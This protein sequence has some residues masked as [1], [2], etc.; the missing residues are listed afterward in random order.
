MPITDVDV[1]GSPGWW[2][3]RLFWQLGNRDRQNRI[4]RLRN[5]RR[6]NATLPEGAENAREA[7]TAFQRKARANWAGLVVSAMTDRMTI[8]GFQT[9]QD[10]DVTGDAEVGKL[11]RRARLDVQS[12][13]VHDDLFTYGEAYVIVG[14]L[15]EELGAPIITREDPRFCYGEPDPEVPWRL[16]AAL[17]ILHDDAQA[18]DRAYLYLP[19]RLTRSGRTELWVARRR[20]AA[21][22]ILNRPL[23]MAPN[24]GFSPASWD[25]YPE[26]ST[27]LP[28]A[29]MPVVRM[30]NK[31]AVGE[32]ESAIDVIDR[33]N[34]QILQ[35]MVIT[36]MQAFRQ[37]A[38]SGLP[39]RDDGTGEEIDYSEVFTLDPAAIWQLPDT[40]K[41][42]ESGV[43]DLTPILSAVKDDIRE[44]G[45]TT[46]TPLHMVQPEGANQSAEGATLV[47]EALVFKVKDRIARA[48][49]PWSQVMQLALIHAGMGERA[50]LAALEPLW[51]SAEHLS[52]AEK[53][54]AASKAQNDIPRRSR[55]VHIWGFPGPV[56]DRM[57]SE[58]ADDALFQAQL[59]AAAG[60]TPD[61]AATAAAGATRPA[62]EPTVAVDNS[63]SGNGSGGGAEAA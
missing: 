54:D 32:F 14:A 53:A 11:W 12:A 55:L 25:W 52:L 47:R 19:G 39:L 63:G 17:K 26:R 5:Y 36:T 2:L 30:E 3:K 42:W 33:I 20:S 44:L 34:H 49:Y 58:W 6:G 35:R 38:V 23:N 24:I 9:S 37:R 50:D 46:A 45:A 40:A 61:A 28:H 41:M 51:A 31:D 43:V 27:V 59:L 4:A 22:D 29:R 13:D 56:A 10:D 1:Q 57:M 48:G 21:K 8:T 16:Q 62:P 18:E 60:A 15:D 7:F